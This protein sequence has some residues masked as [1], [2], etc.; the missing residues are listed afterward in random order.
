MSFQYEGSTEFKCNLHC[1]RCEATNKNGA[2][3]KKNTWK[4]Q[5]YKKYG[6]NQNYVDLH[7]YC[8]NKTHAH[9]KHVFFQKSIFL[10][11]RELI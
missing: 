1:H 8:Q 5:K 9:L 2:R 3:C 11:K 6:F 4:Q 7:T 10:C